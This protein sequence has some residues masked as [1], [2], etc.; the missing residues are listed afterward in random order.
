MYSP[1]G[2]DTSAR[3]DKSGGSCPN[4]SS[5]ETQENVTHSKGHNR[6]QAEKAPEGGVVRNK[7]RVNT[8]SPKTYRSSGA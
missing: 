5:R 3:A 4:P 6:D 8:K 7:R 2:P 1:S